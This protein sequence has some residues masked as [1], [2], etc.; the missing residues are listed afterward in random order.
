MS[1]KIIKPGVFSTIQDLGR[2]QFLDQAVPVSGALDRLATRIA[3]ELL[4][5]HPNDAVVELAYGGMEFIAESDILISIVGKGDS[6]KINGVNTP[7]NRSVYIPKGSLIF[8]GHQKSGSHI[9]IAIAGGWDIPEVLG[10]KST[11]LTG[12]F[13]GF[14]G[15]RLEKDDVLSANNKLSKIT[16]LILN[17]LK[18]EKVNY[19]KWSIPVAQFL[20]EKNHKIRV[21]LGREWDW[22]M[23]NSQEDFLCKP[24]QLSADSNRMGYRLIGAE[25]TRKANFQQELL[26]TAV[27]PGIIQVTG[28]GALILLMADCQTTG[29]YPRLA[30]VIEIDLPICAQLKPSDQLFFEAISLKEAEKLYLNLQKDLDR[31]KL[32][33]RMKWDN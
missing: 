32:A 11:F 1:I 18:G 3:N 21:I 27:V 16:Q 26:S 31:L 12:A 10:S 9:Y 14:K 29:G 15:R 5:N 23:K 19:P 33:I 22:F 8:L 2:T 6:F 30:K 20:P 7:L 13:G 17:R 4:G 25:L 28:N 24:Y